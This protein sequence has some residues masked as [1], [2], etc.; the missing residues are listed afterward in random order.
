MIESPD[1]ATC[2]SMGSKFPIV[3]RLARNR[4]G[5]CGECSWVLIA[6]ENMVHVLCS[7]QRTNTDIQHSGA[8]ANFSFDD[9]FSYVHFIK[10]YY[11]IIN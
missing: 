7:F 1:F 2:V 5:R 6:Y 9:R 11:V 4:T 8:Y 3:M 10:S